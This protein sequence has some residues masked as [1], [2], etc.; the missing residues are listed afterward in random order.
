MKLAIT[1]LVGTLEALLYILRVRLMI[2]ERQVP[3]EREEGTKMER[4]EVE[5]EKV[6]RRQENRG[7]R[8]AKYKNS[9]KAMY[10]EF[11]FRGIK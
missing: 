4:N 6:M 1:A 8:G 10:I 11:N 3:G 5:D 9:I 7:Q 2:R